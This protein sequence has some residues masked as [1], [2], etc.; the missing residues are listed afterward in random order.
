MSQTAE[1]TTQIDEADLKYRV[2]EYKA[3]ADRF[4]CLDEDF[5]PIE[6]DHI[7]GSY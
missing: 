7:K 2:D 5:L 3:E 1:Q 6:L 4:R